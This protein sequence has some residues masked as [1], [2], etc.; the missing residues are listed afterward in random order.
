MA[1]KN[2]IS[3]LEMSRLGGLANAASQTPAERSARASRAAKIRWDAY[4]Y[5]SKKEST[6]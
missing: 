5:N 6:K 2:G 3:H 1:S 4:I